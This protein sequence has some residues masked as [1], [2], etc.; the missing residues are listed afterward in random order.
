MTTPDLTLILQKARAGDEDAKAAV[1]PLV[2][3]RLRT[4]AR[5]KMGRVRSG[6]T[7][8]PTALVHEAYMR[9]LGGEE[10]FENRRHF[11]FV[12]ARAMRDIL[13][14][15][16]RQKG[17]LKRGGDMQQVELD[18]A[19][20][21]IEPPSIDMLGL[22]QALEALEGENDRCHE[23]VM[24]RYFAGVT[25]E[26]CAELLGVGLRTVERDWR[27]ARAFLKDHMERA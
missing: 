24:L 14:E 16:A 19:V 21:S 4:L 13:V 1:L 5:S 26:D 17:R 6:H 12:A 8:Q 7:L 23:V 27:F 9:S 10:D 15:H 25:A 22:H 18:A 3:E 2:Y 11:F 20:A